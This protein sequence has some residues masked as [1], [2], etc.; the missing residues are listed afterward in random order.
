MS[1]LR[2]VRLLTRNSIINN[3]FLGLRSSFHPIHRSYA[4]LSDRD[5]IPGSQATNQTVDASIY[6]SARNDSSYV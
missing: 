3:K 4:T 6:A 2:S 5:A 1:L